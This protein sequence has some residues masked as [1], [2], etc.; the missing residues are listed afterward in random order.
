MKRIL[1][2]LLLL[3]MLSCERVQLDKEMYQN[4]VGF[5]HLKNQIVKDF[6][7]LDLGIEFV[8]LQ[9]SGS[10]IPPDNRASSMLSA[11]FVRGDDKNHMV[12]YTL[13]S[14]SRFFKN[15]VD[16]SVGDF[17]NKKISNTYETYQPHIFSEKDFD[18]FVVNEVV[19]KSVEMFRKDA[20]SPDAFCTLAGI[21]RN[22]KGELSIDVTVTQRQFASTIRRNYEWSIDGKTLLN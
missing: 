18:F 8:E 14:D 15:N 17:M 22:K 9:Y 16:V 21:E 12:E 2:P 1:L 19:E 13:D 6:P 5:D 4:P 3:T 20:N 11:T 7:T 10:L